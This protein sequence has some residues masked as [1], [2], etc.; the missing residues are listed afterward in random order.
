MKNYGILTSVFVSILFLFAFS[1]DQVPNLTQPRPNVFA[2]GQPTEAGFQEL[3]AMGIRTVINVLPEPQCLKG[4]QNMVQMNH[5]VY[6]RLPFETATLTRD[7]VDEFGY[8]MMTSEQPVLIHCTT[9]NH[10]GGL[11][12]AYRVSVEHAPVSVALREAR[13]IGIQPSMENMVLH[14][15][16]EQTNVVK[17]SSKS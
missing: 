1:E 5:M 11:W 10:V 16:G 12:L 8:L 15:L 2:C 13:K 14:W 3:A 17:T 4:E 9:G 7:T 6:K